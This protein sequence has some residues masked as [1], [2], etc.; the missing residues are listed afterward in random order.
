MVMKISGSDLGRIPMGSGCHWADVGQ[1]HRTRAKQTALMQIHK[2]PI[3]VCAY[4]LFEYPCLTPPAGAHLRDAKHRLVMYIHTAMLSRRRRPGR[5]RSISSRTCLD[6]G[7]SHP[8][9]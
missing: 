6:C 5:R 4:F 2:T 9:S 3:S 1:L 7:D 8:T